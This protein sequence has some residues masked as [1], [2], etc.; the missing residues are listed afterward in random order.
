MIVNHLRV[1]AF[2]GLKIT[3]ASSGDRFS[4][5]LAEPT[6]A[7]I[8]SNSPTSPSLTSP[9]PTKPKRSCPLGLHLDSGDGDGDVEL[10]KS[11]G[12][13]SSPPALESQGRSVRSSAVRGSNCR[14]HCAKFETRSAL[15]DSAY[16]KSVGR[17]PTL[18]SLTVPEECEDEVVLRQPP[19]SET[20]TERLAL[21]GL[22]LNSSDALKYLT[23]QLSVKVLVKLLY[24]VGARE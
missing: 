2:Q 8:T 3:S 1:A 14:S 23:D 19:A 15:N 4:V 18:F 20:Q 5:V 9:A 17:P 13:I 24:R 16:I 21:S 12:A 6:S 10:R 11:K 7:R 22:Y